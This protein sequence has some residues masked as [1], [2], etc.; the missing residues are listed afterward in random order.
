MSRIKVGEPSQKKTLS[1]SQKSLKQIPP[2]WLS[3]DR[4]KKGYA[5]RYDQKCKRFRENQ[6][7][8]KML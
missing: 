8:E 1:L 4:G 2:L 6:I 3:K 5:R 7:R